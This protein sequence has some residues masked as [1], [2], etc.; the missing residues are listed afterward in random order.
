VAQQIPTLGYGPGGSIAF[1]VRLGFGGA[2]AP[3]TRTYPTAV[4]V[5]PAVATTSPRQSVIVTTRN[6]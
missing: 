5:R 1:I 2:A 3:P 6:A 4:I